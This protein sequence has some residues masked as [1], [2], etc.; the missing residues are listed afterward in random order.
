MKTSTA[1]S[2]TAMLEQEG[3]AILETISLYS[4]LVV[5]GSE[6]AVDLQMYDVEKCFDA[7][8]LQECINDIYEAGLQNDKLPLLFM[9]NSNAKVAAKT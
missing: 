6:K 5:K 1:T 8:W 3:P 4:M 7:L 9:E 2:L